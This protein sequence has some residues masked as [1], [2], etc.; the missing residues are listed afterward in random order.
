MSTYCP[1]GGTTRDSVQVRDRVGCIGDGGVSCSSDLTLLCRRAAIE[2][3]R[4]AG[5][6]A[7][8]VVRDTLKG[9]E[10]AIDLE[11]V[12][13]S[14]GSNGGELSGGIDV[15][16]DIASR[17]LVFASARASKVVDTS[18]VVGQLEGLARCEHGELRGFPRLERE[19]WGAEIRSKYQSR[20]PWYAQQWPILTT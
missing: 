18:E 3:N 15:L 2:S 14:V 5:N 17:E 13:L 10:R 19:L 11:L 8:I 6:P 12:G 7:P 1:A 9:G 20:V 4:T 16:K